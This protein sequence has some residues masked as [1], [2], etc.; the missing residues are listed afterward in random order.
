MT[1]LVWLHNGSRLMR[2]VYCSI[3]LVFHPFESAS[4]KV[5]KV[6]TCNRVTNSNPLPGPFRLVLRIA[7]M[8]HL[9]SK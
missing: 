6:N 9:C 5:P 2:H 4:P 1:V 8:L 7:V 3:N